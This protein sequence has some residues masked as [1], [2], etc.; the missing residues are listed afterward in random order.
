M[1]IDFLIFICK[2]PFYVVR[3]SYAVIIIEYF[4]ENREMSSE[5]V[6]KTEYL[7]HRF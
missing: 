2:N 6:L 7:N 1:F 4:S 3:T 5:P